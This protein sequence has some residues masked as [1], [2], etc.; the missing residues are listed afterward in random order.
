M[1]EPAGGLTLLFTDVEG[2]TALLRELKGSYG[3][4]LRIHQRMLE[5]CVEDHHGS[6]MGSE[7]D[8]L[9]FVFSTPDDAIAAA[10]AA[11][12]KADHYD[13]PDGIHLRVRI[14]VHTGRVTISGGEYTGLTVHEV[15]RICAAAHGGQILCSSAVADAVEWSR[16]GATLS[17]L[18]VF[19]LRGFPEGQRLFQVC[20][21]GLQQDFPS[22]R[23]THRDGGA[24]VSVWFR[25]APAPTTPDSPPPVF[26]ALV[27]DVEIEVAPAT[28]GVPGAFRLIVRQGGAV[29][30]EFDGL[31]DGGP[32]D[33]A[34]IVA[35]HSRLVRVA[36]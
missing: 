23:D 31:T 8:A 6:R 30:E 25:D 24:R 18:G 11:Q 4:T 29:A 10:I 26:E 17:D 22:L 2:S 34:T 12:E 3:L 33:A 28:P 13:W 14:G 19:V 15:A 16:I 27:D 9:F 21:D 1:E 7:G 36:R 5:R 35:A 32:T 20:V